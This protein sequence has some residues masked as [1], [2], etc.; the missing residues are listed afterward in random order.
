MS[1]TFGVYSIARTGMQA[2]QSALTVTSH[3]L[4]NLNTAGYSRQQVRSVATVTA[5]SG[6]QTEGTGV[7]VNE[8][9]R[10]RNELL[11]NAYHKKNATASYWSTKSGML[12]Y[13]QQILDEFS[14]TATTRTTDNN[15]LQLKMT[16]FFNSWD[17]LSQEPGSVNNRKEVIEQAAA[18]LDCFRKA[19]EDLANLQRDAS[20]S[21][22]DIVK[23]INSIAEQVAALNV[24]IAQAEATY[25]QA[26]DLRDQRDYLL[27]SLSNYTNF[28]MQEQANGSVSVEIGGVALVSMDKTNKLAV[29][30]D[31]SVGHPLE[32]QWVGLDQT[33][34]I[35]SGTLKACLEDADQTGVA[36]ITNPASYNYSADAISSISNLRQG[37]N[38]VITTLAVKI[39]DLHKAG[40]GL[41]GSTGID[42]FVPVNTNEPLSIDNM[43]VNPQI[44]SNSNKL[45]A[46]NTGQKGDNTVADAIADLKTA[47]L[48][49]SDG[50]SQDITG[51][52][53]SLVTWVGTAGSNA[54][55]YYDTAS[56]L[57]N[58]VDNQRQGMSS[59]SLDEEMSNMIMFQNAYGASARVLST[60]DNLIAGL[61]QELG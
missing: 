22:K 9:V 49:K 41:D 43:Q 6:H 52:Y 56:T 2:N 42:F 25:A 30:G 48:Y 46:G 3:N 40:K 28:S 10:A 1:S 57:A 36:A 55:G 50:L 15:G 59:V 27:D 60:M 4:S 39:N 34:K 11:D 17:E 19:D 16:D 38:N 37:L 13:A 53:Q 61:I 24:Q 45:A 14:T 32:V 20:N 8:V 5:Y 31:G 54:S 21:T 18:L 33:A 7:G 51:F 29:T 26:G 35:T 44:A 12:T 23:E 58:Q 47:K